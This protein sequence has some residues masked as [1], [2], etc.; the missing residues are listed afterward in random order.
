MYPE[1][2]FVKKVMA[3]NQLTVIAIGGKHKNLNK[4]KRLWKLRLNFGSTD[5]VELVDMTVCH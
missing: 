5:N 2:L 1:N 3:L 4:E